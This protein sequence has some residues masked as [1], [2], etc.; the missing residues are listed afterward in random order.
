MQFVRGSAEAP[1]F[2]TFSTAVWV[3]WKDGRPDC[4]SSKKITKSR[5]CQLLPG[6]N[7]TRHNRRRLCVREYKRREKVSEGHTSFVLPLHLLVIIGYT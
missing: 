2:G 3:P 1:R 4:L 5:R 7:E 6:T